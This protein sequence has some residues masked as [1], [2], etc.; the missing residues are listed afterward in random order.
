MGSIGQ[1]CSRSILKSRPLRWDFGTMLFMVLMETSWF[2]LTTGI[3]GIFIIIILSINWDQLHS[4][5]DL[6]TYTGTL[7]WR[8]M[9]SVI[10]MRHCPSQS[11]KDFLNQDR[12]AWHASVHGVSK[13]WTWLSDWTTKTHIFSYRHCTS[14]SFYI[15]TMIH[16]EFFYGVIKELRFSV[17][18]SSCYDNIILED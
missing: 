8:A 12:E 15:Q 14:F 16:F 10:S 1:N 11:H 3:H 2:K 18:P 5:G 7:V 13:S 17:F 6:L 4:A 9:E